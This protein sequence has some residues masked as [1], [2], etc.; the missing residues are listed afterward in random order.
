MIIAPP[1]NVI[2]N[3]TNDPNII[4]G[5]KGELHASRELR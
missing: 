3:C 5:A 2:A 4:A 1:I